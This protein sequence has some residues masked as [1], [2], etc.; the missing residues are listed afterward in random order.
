M[1]MNRILSRP[2]WANR[3]I[4]SVTDVTTPEILTEAR[5]SANA[6]HINLGPVQKALQKSGVGVPY[7]D[8]RRFLYIFLKSK[9][10]VDGTVPSTAKA[11]NAIFGELAINGKLPEGI[12]T[13]FDAYANEKLENYVKSI[14]GMRGRIAADDDVDVRIKDPQAETS[15][16][17]E[18][19]DWEEI[20]DKFGHIELRLTGVDRYGYYNYKSQPRKDIGIASVTTEAPVLDSTGE[21]KATLLLHEL[22]PQFI[23]SARI[24]HEGDAPMYDPVFK[25][26]DMNALDD[27]ETEDGYD[28]EMDSEDEESGRGYLGGSDDG[29]ATKDPNV[30][31]KTPKKLPTIK[32]D[33]D[34]PTDMREPFEA[35]GR[36]EE[37]SSPYSTKIARML[38]ELEDIPSYYGNDSNG[39][40][41]AKE[42][43]MD[44][45]QKLI[46]MGADPHDVEQYINSGAYNHFDKKE[47][48]S[49]LHSHEKNNQQNSGN[50]HA[51]EGYSGNSS[52]YKGRNPRRN[53][54]Q[55]NISESEAKSYAPSKREQNRLIVE[56]RI[57]KNKHLFRNE[58]RGASF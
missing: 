2:G 30:Y 1:N 17:N 48:I 39:E 5:S 31:T 9:G 22:E 42:H 41:Y 55:H 11:V 38:S 3:N 7:R 50:V 34:Y 37:E 4:N 19:N 46:D 10:L 25:K 23:R 28:D 57:N 51:M 35:N 26:I 16:G 27:D 21:P 29:N 36:S 12:G 52:V 49:L 44:H 43:A 58:E 14:G 33:K 56:N 13:E 18:A 53:R 24:G 6:S 54:G 47:I 8:A 20:V 32:R 40:D 15:Y 45:V